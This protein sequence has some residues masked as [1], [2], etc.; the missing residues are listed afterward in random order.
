MLDNTKVGLYRGTKELKVWPMTRG[1]YNDYRGLELPEGEDG[2]EYGYLV[3]YLD[4]G[5]AN[6][7]RHSGYISWSPADVFDKMYYRT[8]CNGAS[9][10]QCVSAEHFE[11][12]LRGPAPEAE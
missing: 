12:Y 8:D 6:D 9:L 3:E 4:G 1:E 10:G 5:R 2:E 7:V 11:A